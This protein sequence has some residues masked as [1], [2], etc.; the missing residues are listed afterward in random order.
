MTNFIS[1]TLGN[2]DSLLSSLS[3]MGLSDMEA[4]MLRSME[5]VNMFMET[6]IDKLES[7]NGKKLKLEAEIGKKV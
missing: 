7:K 1:S 4:S 5:A 3:D 2:S 6:L